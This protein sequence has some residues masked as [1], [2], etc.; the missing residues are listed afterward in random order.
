MVSVFLCF[1]LQ[2][3]NLSFAKL[4]CFIEKAASSKRLCHA[5]IFTIFFFLLLTLVLFVLWHFSILI[6][7]IAINPTWMCKYAYMQVLGM[8]VCRYASVQVCKYVSTQVWKYTNMQK[9][10]YAS[11]HVCK[12]ASM[13]VCNLQVCKCVSIQVSKYTRVQV[14]MLA[15]MHYELFCA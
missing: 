8:Q 5:V 3:K 7:A 13:Q 9:C 12:Y 6:H 1:S 15:R 11:M 4:L 10:E 14:C 2:T